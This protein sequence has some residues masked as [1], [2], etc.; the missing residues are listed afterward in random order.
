MNGYER[1]VKE[2]LKENGWSFLRH[3]KGSHDIWTDGSNH[4]TVNHNCKSRF[5]ANRIMK[6]AGIKHKF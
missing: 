3:G 6:D 5:T 2:L 1:Q 4:V